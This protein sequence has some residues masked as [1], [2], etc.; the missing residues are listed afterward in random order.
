M[1]YASDAVS[2]ADIKETKAAEARKYLYNAQ[3]NCPYWHGVFGGLYL[4]HLRSSVYTNCINAEKT[5]LESA[6]QKDPL[7][8][9]VLDIDKDGFD[10][11]ILENGPLG[12][13]VAPHEGGAILELDLRAKSLNITNTMMRR[14]EPYHAKIR[15]KIAPGAL[16]PA[17]G[18][19]SIHDAVVLKEK[20]LD[21][22]LQY[23]WHR[24]AFAVDHFLGGGATP[25]SFSKAAFPETGDFASAAYAFELKKSPS[26]VSL[27][28]ERTGIVMADTRPCA[29]TV[30]KRFALEA[31]KAE[32]LIAYKIKNMTDADVP[33]WFGSEYNISLH[34]PRFCAVGALNDLGS[35]RIADEWFKVTL[36]YT[37]SKKAGLWYYPLE[38]VSESESGFEKT[39]Q[40]MCLLLHWKG[41]LKPR[42]SW[43]V[44]ITFGVR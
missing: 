44:E 3:C 26:A 19:A 13:F 10:E 40:Q 39:F 43:S 33:F 32:I 2:E 7:R 6:R 30:E 12:I 20:N 11:V 42:Q 9:E 18:V 21:N 16:P 31:K 36:N 35:L 25:E 17:A 22:F 34:D 5:A 23:D 29:V 8:A 28:L 4:H 37:M 38:T 1:V 27:E 15:N 24:K 41:M 14:C